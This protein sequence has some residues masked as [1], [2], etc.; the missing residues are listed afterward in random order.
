MT[1]KIIQKAWLGTSDVDEILRRQRKNVVNS[2]VSRT[3]EL[4]ISRRIV[5]RETPV[6]SES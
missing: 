2:I 1:K 5:D 6:R 3:M 4:S